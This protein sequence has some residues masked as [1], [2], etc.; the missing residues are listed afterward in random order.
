MYHTKHILHTAI[1]IALVCAT[2]ACTTWQDET[3]ESSYILP[4][5]PDPEYKFNRN[6]KS[7]VDLLECELLKEPADIIYTSFLKEARISGIAQQERLNEYFTQGLYGKAPSNEI[8]ASAMH[9]PYK[10]K[11]D[12]TFQNI[13]LQV[14]ALSGYN[15]P[16][17]YNEIRNTRAQMGKGGFLGYNIG[18]ANI[19][20]VNN[21][22]IAPA[23][24]YNEMIRGCIYLDKIINVHLLPQLYNDKKLIADQEISNLMPGH[25]YTELEHHW[26][27]AYGYYQ[28]WLPIVQKNERTALKGLRIKLYNA[29]ATGRLALTEY[30]FDEARECLNII[31]QELSKVAAVHAIQLLSGETTKVNLQEDV[32]NALVFLSRAYGAIFSL[33]FAINAQG[34]PLY[35][36]NEVQQLLSTLQQA[37]GLWEQQRLQADVNTPGSIAFV[38][39]NIKQHMQ[40]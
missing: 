18:D 6:N 5:Y 8:A 32:S 15:H 4:T 24:V 1:L 37:N 17:N 39:N 11:I 31:R 23:E 38:V 10:T 34:K 21:K 33:Q 25:N 29:F 12:S 19:A 9:K 27:L 16:N 40:Q 28:Y 7:S 26:D 30:R 20:F 35:T 13:F 14:Q 3:I 36:Y 22:G 2:M